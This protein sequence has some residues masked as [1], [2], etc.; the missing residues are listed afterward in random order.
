MANYADVQTNS[1]SLPS[2]SDQGKDGKEFDGV[3]RFACPVGFFR[4]KRNCYY[5]SAGVAQWRDAYYH[6]RDRNSSLAVLDKNGKDRLLRK[7]LMGDQ[8]S[9]FTNLF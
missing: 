2:S 9:K 3:R 6:C 8:F 4:L 7:Y 5:L 1:I